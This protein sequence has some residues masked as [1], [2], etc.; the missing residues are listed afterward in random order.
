M[1]LPADFNIEPQY[2]RENPNVFNKMNFSEQELNE[3][4]RING[5]EYLNDTETT[6]PF[7][8]ILDS[9]SYA[10]NALER[11]LKLNLE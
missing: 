11:R 6:A 8:T 9:I 3:I 1:H 4:K 10:E 7:L 5:E 2:N